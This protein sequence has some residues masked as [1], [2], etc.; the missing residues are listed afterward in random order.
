M[1]T[2]STG[3]TPTAY[4]LQG[5]PAGATVQPQ[6]VPAAG[7]FTFQVSGGSCAS[8]Y[9]F[10]VVA[11]FPNG[12]AAS[13]PSIPVRPCIP[14]TAPQNVRAQPMNHEADLTWSAPASLGG[15]GPITYGLT[16]SG[17]TSSSQQGISGTADRVTGLV[18]GGPYQFK[19]TAADPAGSGGSAPASAT[20]VGP[21][22]GYP[23]YRHPTQP[24]EVRP[25]P[26]TAQSP[27]ASIPV[28][29]NPTVTVVCQ[30]S[31]AWVQDNGDPTLHGSIWDQVDWS[32]RT[33]YI[34][35]LYVSTPQSAAGNYANYSYPPLYQCT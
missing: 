27:I 10:T 8:L 14:P 4:L 31:G 18:N 13:R 17:A 15:G 25:A 35:D 33:A 28:G 16:W 30:V 24:L 22:V 23:V 32:G 26:T 20:L 3:A 34:S 29:Q 19:L 9:A 1:F 12:Q 6:Q 21:R 5:A 7:P 11:T 2:P